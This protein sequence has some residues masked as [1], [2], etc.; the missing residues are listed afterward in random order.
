MLSVEP[1]SSSPQF[2]ASVP[3]TLSLTA[4]GAPLS[5]AQV[6]LVVAGTTRSVTTDAKGQGSLTVESLPV[7]KQSLKVSYPG[8]AGHL[9]SMETA[10]LSVQAATA[11][12]KLTVTP[13]PTGATTVLAEVSTSTGVA[14]TGSID[15]SVD[16]TAVNAAPVTDGQATAEIAGTLAIGEHTV[17]VNFVPGNVAELTT[18]TATAKITVTKAGSAVSATADKDA[19]RY[20]DSSAFTISVTSVIPGADLTGAVTVLDGATTVA[21]G[22]TDAAGHSSISFLNRADPGAKTYT[23]SY[24][25][26]A[27]VEPSRADFVVNTTQT[28][29]DIGITKPS[30][31]TPGSNATITVAIIGTPDKP[32]GVTTVTY[33]GT[34]IAGGALDADGKISGAVAGVTEGSHTIAVTYAGDARF[35]ANT[36]SSTLTVKAP[37]VNPNADG[38]AGINAGNPC[39]ASASACVDLSNQLAWLQSGGQV[40]YGPVAI[41][42]GR[43]GHRTEA[44]TFTVFWL[45]KNHKSTLFND[46]PMP[47][48]VFFDGGI[49]FHQG[50][51]SVQSHG[52]VHLSGSAS[53]TFF[54]TLSV[55]DQVY[56]FGAAPY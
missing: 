42:S 51:L 5:G 18:T 54:T 17:A 26:S 46:A 56:V 44:G 25:G 29:V 13:T 30:G 15:V 9:A 11:T 55:G 1:A 45:D 12:L 28:N 36:A 20:G 53:L 23:I 22:A 19:V 10:A 7:G 48:S 40:T 3:V 24:A 39:P 21:E 34:Q 38:A 49:A 31:L 33:D 14:A 8:D 32:T 6:F 4:G 27:S 47:N 43:A 50:S 41:T 37:I 2:G 52:C 35:E 16:G